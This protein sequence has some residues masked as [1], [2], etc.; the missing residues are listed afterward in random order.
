VYL[1][2]DDSFIICYITILTG[3]ASTGGSVSWDDGQRWTPKLL[4]TENN[5][6]GLAG[7][8]NVKLVVVS[9]L[10]KRNT[11]GSALATLALTTTVE[12]KRLNSMLSIVHD[13][14]RLVREKIVLNRV[15][16]HKQIHGRVINIEVLERHHIINVMRLGGSKDDTNVFA[17]GEGVEHCDLGEF[18]IT[19]GGEF[20]GEVAA[21]VVLVVAVG[22]LNALQAPFFSASLY[23][24][25]EGGGVH[26]TLEPKIFLSHESLG[27]NWCWKMDGD[28]W[29]SK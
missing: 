10:D 9:R 29:T 13:K 22:F 1:C 28:G 4:Y 15:G 11:L 23:G 21:S 5:R 7:C 27:K 16:V 2:S 20:D 19:L 26:F 24:I 12:C 6:L 17:L 8:W 14:L 25:V 3:G 18:Q